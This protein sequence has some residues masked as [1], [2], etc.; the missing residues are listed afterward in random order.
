M[1]KTEATMKVKSRLLQYM[2]L[3]RTHSLLTGRNVRIIFDLFSL[4]DV[5]D[6]L[7]LNDVQFFAFLNSVTDL[8]ESQ[9]YSVFDMLDVDGSGSIDFNEFYLLI[10]IFIAVQDREEKQ[11]IYRHSKTVFSLLDEDNSGSI[12]AEEFQQLGFLFN[13][14][15]DAINQIF[16]EFDVSGDQNLDYA[17]FKMFAMECIDRQGDKD[18]KFRWSSLMNCT[19]L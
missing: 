10:C 4:I 12:S 6:D 9:S 11:F 14:Q 8:T 7:S 1:I 3:N 2:H 17:E 13:M 18:D 19:I 15:G 16:S 5:H